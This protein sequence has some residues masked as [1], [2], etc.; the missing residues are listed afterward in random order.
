MKARHKSSARAKL[1]HLAT[2]SFGLIFG[3]VLA[4]YVHQVQRERAVYKNLERS[5]TWAAWQLERQF[6]HFLTA[7]YE[8][9]Q[10][11]GPAALD[12]LRLQFELLYSRPNILLTGAE[13]QLVR[14]APGVQE[15]LTRF[16]AFLDRI[17]AD[18]HRLDPQ[19]RR[20]IVQ[21]RDELG[22]YAG[23]VS[24]ISVLASVGP[25][26]RNLRQSAREMKELSF[27]LQ[28]VLILAA[29]TL[30][31][32]LAAEVWRNRRLARTE[33]RLRNLADLANGALRESEQRYRQLVQ[34]SGAVPYTL[35]LSN[36]KF[37][38]VGPQAVRLLGYPAA[39][40]I[41]AEFWQ[42][43]LFEDDRNETTL[44]RAGNL[45]KGDRSALRY[46]MRH[47]DGH[48]VWIH[49]II[50]VVREADD[51]LVGYG[52]LFD[53]TESRRRDQELASAQRMEAI[54]QLTGG[55][56]H[57]F[58][59]LLTVVTGNLELLKLKGG[60]N[61][62][63]APIVERA[64]VGTSRGAALTRQLLSFARRQFLE[65]RDFDANGLIEDMVELMRRAL[66]EQ[67]RIV[68][69]LEPS[70]WTA[71]ADPTQVDSALM[72]L[73]INSRDAM[74]QGGQITIASANRRLPDSVD[75]P[76]DDIAP[77]DY[78]ML[79]VTDTGI[80]MPQEVL[81]RAFEPFFTTKR[82]GEGTGLGLSMVFGFIRQSR[83]HIEIES[84]VGKGT[85]VR[86]H[87]PRGRTEVSVSGDD[88]PTRLDVSIAGARVLLVED[89]PDVRQIALAHLRDLG[90][91]VAE[92]TNGPAALYIL[93]NDKSFDLLFTDI[94]MPE[95]MSGIDLGKIVK[96]RNPN[97]KILFTTGFFEQLDDASRR[98]DGIGLLLRKPYSRSELEYMIR[99]TLTEGAEASEGSS[100]LLRR[101]RGS[102]W[103]Q[104]RSA[105][106]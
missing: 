43:H 46:R 89:N 73:A 92:A 17:E 51:R 49:D 101:R 52:L 26:A 21:L 3:V 23:D 35:E 31:S 71:Y 67:V 102:D 48:F 50:N 74:P 34:S 80:G 76:R 95:G 106:S 38:Y 11:P 25:T 6:L 64:L 18:I 69:D 61:E 16:V 99:L 15:L 60:L 4:V 59:N 70:L 56:A 85:T 27:W 84:E 22:R 100:I 20:K 13:T 2:I 29:T 78:V 24:K 40:W 57:D 68:T 62:H 55:I 96:A 5:N 33:T 54:G 44:A 104:A 42:Q 105:T 9:E 12:E 36:L 83:G 82:D 90:C 7:L 39:D 94:V 72:N 66:G 91:H 97:L 79:S 19:D 37:S 1:R 65:A 93:S 81:S 32:V 75:L 28:I 103:A 98:I 47:A 41:A 63:A 58:N 86:V 14:A 45:Q 88:E 77:G 87:L 8:L 53:E 30:V 10:T